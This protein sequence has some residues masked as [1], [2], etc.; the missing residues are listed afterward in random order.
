MVKHNNQ[1]P[2]QHFHKKWGDSSRGPIHVITWFDQPAKKKQRRIKRAAKAAAVAPR[3]AAL[4][5]P[6]VHCPTVK[7]AS[8][9]RLGRGFSFAEL[10][11][12]G[13][14]PAFA[15]TIGIAVDH[16]RTNKSAES[17]QTNVDRLKMYKENLILFP[18]KGTKAKKGDC[19]PEQKATVLGGAATVTT[20]KAVMPLVKPAAD[21]VEMVE[22]TD[23]MKETRS[24]YENRRVR[25]EKKMAGIRKKMAEDK[26][27]EK[28]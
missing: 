21:D 28:K 26:L 20:G 6:A 3:P 23:E 1:V 14:A 19:T 13:M 24:Y 12:A 2:N 5:R 27:K 7:Y 22:I 15:K 4:L 11:G 17:L 25:N 18:R 9:V 16:R 8:K 10:K